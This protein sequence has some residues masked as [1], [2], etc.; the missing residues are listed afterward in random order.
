[1]NSLDRIMDKTKYLGDDSKADWVADGTPQVYDGS[2]LL[3]MAPGT[4]GT[5]LASSFY[6]WY[7]SVSATLKTSRSQGVVTAF[8]LLS[9]V[10]DEI[11]YEFVG[12]ELETAQTN[13]YYQGVPNYDNELN[14][15]LSNT[16]ENSHTYQ[17]DWTPDQITWSVDG[18]VGRTKKRSDTWNA[19]ANQYY[20]PQTPARIQ[21]S[22][23]PGGDPS[24]GEGTIQWSGGPIDWTNAPD[25]KSNGYYYAQVTDVTVS[26]YNVPAGVQQS[27]TTSYIYDNDSGTNSSVQIT[28]KSTI[29]KSLLGTGTNMSADYPSGSAAASA[30]EVAQVPGLSGVGGI[31]AN[32][33]RGSGTGSS[34]T[35][36]SGGASATAAGGFSQGGSSTG[37][38][39]GAVGGVEPDRMLRG[40]IFAGLVAVVG[41]MIL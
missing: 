25:I 31:G 33:D 13:Y 18:Q 3:T 14:I 2:V 30:S 12:V 6:V 39:S 34:G 9:D 8:I 32:G 17:I 26:C 29:L 19:T 28:G 20:Y 41:V 36:S 38:K 11:D 35:G 21:L 10:K 1:M 22:I 40:S 7:G 15:S 23:W 16:F 4:V 5:V 37:K 24:N 27:G